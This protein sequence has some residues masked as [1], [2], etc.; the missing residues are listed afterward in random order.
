M[1]FSVL[2]NYHIQVSFNLNLKVILYAA[3]ITQ[4]AATELTLNGYNIKF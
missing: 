1:V 4:N 2:L 3:K